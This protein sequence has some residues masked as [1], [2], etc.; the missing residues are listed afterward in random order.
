MSSDDDDPA[1]LQ[2][3][4][5]FYPSSRVHQFGPDQSTLM[6]NVGILTLKLHGQD[7]DGQKYYYSPLIAFCP[8]MFMTFIAW[9][10]YSTSFSVKM[11]ANSKQHSR[12][13]NSWC[14]SLV[15]WIFRLSCLEKRRPHTEFPSGVKRPQT[16]LWSC[17]GTLTVWSTSWKQVKQLRD[18]SQ[19][20]YNYLERISGGCLKMFTE[21]ST[22]FGPGATDSCA[23][24]ELTS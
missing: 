4:H 9:K 6:N 11:Q 15:W 23:Y 18:I 21:N 2:K 16:R 5:V 19:I 22:T 7:A 24:P 14:E 3:Q 12:F 8:Y 1:H 20:L 13:A 17:G 10:S